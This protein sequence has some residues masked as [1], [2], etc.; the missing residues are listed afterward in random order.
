MPC[1]PG[2]AFAPGAKLLQKG[3]RREVLLHL[4]LRSTPRWVF[5]EEMARSKTC[6]LHLE[7]KVP[8]PVAMPKINVTLIRDGES[9]R[10]RLPRAP[11]SAAPLCWEPPSSGAARSQQEPGSAPICCRHDALPLLPRHFQH[12]VHEHFFCL[13]A[14]SSQR[15]T[16]TVQQKTVCSRW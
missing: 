9:G 4:H 8:T 6:T 12:P 10:R 11:A 14:L 3:A 1:Y 7:L 2:V 15:S 13:C 5:M 16:S